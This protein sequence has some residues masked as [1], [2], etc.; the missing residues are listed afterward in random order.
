[1]INSTKT[2]IQS[3]LVLIV[4][5]L[6]SCSNHEKKSEKLNTKKPYKILIEA[7]DMML[8]DAKIYSEEGKSGDKVIKLLSEEA[9]AT[10]EITLPKGKYVMNAFMKTQDEMSDGF[11]LIANG[12]V[13]RIN[14]YRFNQWLHGMKFIIFDSDGVNPIKIE[15]ASSYE[16]QI[17]KEFG[18]FIDYLEIVDFYNSAEA[19]E[20]WTK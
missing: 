3:L 16:G 12:K 14:N 13:K 15:I 7:E 9:M 6:F 1:M 17:S 20:L 4:L 10:T 5:T 19:L 8:S 11:F 2:L 18:M